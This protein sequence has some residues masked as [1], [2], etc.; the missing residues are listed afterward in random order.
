MGLEKFRT[1]TSEIR[2]E[3]KETDP[4]LYEGLDRLLKDFKPVSGPED[5]VGSDQL[6]PCLIYTYTKAIAPEILAL[7]A[8]INNFT[9]QKHADPFSFV[10]RTLL[11]LDMFIRNEMHKLDSKTERFTY[12]S[13]RLS[14]S[15]S[16]LL[17]SQILHS[18]K[19]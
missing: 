6:I 1:V 9:L 16:Q 10:E 4:V 12:L 5:M 13:N 2:Q 8:V 3:C 15:H 11:G 18:Q 17:S 19:T 14:Q 7:L